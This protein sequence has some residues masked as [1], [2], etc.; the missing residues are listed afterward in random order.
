MTVLDEA[1]ER[2]K[3]AWVEDQRGFVNHGPM[4]CEALFAMGLDEEVVAW[5]NRGAQS[6]RARTDHRACGGVITA[7][8]DH[9]GQFF[10]LHGWVTH[11]EVTIDKVGWRDTVATWAPRLMPSLETKLFHALIRTAH[12]TGAVENADTGPRRHELAVALGYWAA[13]YGDGRRIIPRSRPPTRRLTSASTR[14]GQRS[15]SW[16]LGPPSDSSPSR[17]FSHS[18]A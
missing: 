2:L 1:Y 4:A 11:F 9:L 5:A 17:M 8:Q 7:W 10:L 6:H 15:P 3:G 16:G 18:T 13:G 14:S 12:A